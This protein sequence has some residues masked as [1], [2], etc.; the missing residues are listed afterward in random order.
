[1]KKNTAIARF[2][3]LIFTC[4]VFSAYDGS[5]GESWDFIKLLRP[6]L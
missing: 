5:R 6:S 3:I 1:M 4:D 2:A